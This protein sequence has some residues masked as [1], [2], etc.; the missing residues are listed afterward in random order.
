M[1][2]N[3]LASSSQHIKEKGTENENTQ[4]NKN[5]K[6]NKSKNNGVLER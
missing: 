5:R 1:K 2:I 6:Q 4:T 3:Q